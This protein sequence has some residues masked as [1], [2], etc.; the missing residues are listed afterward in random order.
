[1]IPV[2][3]WIERRFGDAKKKPHAQSV[4]RWI[5]SGA[6]PGKKIG[7]R[8]FVD[9]ELEQQLTGDELVD[10]VLLAS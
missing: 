9:A 10:R 6:V 2:Q 4:R 3:E 1:M 5:D 7:G 8:Y